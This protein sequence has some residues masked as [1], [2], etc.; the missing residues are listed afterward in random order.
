MVILVTDLTIKDVENI[1][2]NKKLSDN[3]KKSLLYAL[4]QQEE[5]FLVF[6]KAILPKAFSKPSP[7]FHK[8]VIKEFMKPTSSALAAPRNHAKSTLIGLGYLLWLI[9]YKKEEYIIYTS[10]N[11]VKSVQFIEPLLSEIKNNIFY[12]WLYGVM[13][14]K[15]EEEVEGINALERQD[16]F[17]VNGI[18]VQAFS[19][20]KNIRGLKYGIHRPSI[21]I[22]DDIE[23]DDRIINPELRLKDSD[24]LNRQMIPSL[25]AIKGRYKFIGTILHQDSLLM[26]KIRNLDGR[27]YKAI[28]DDGTPLWPEMWPL[29]RLEEQ[30]RQIGSMAFEQEYMNNP[31]NDTF[32][33]IKREWLRA[34]CDEN[35]SYEEA[36]NHKYDSRFQGVDFAFSDRVVADKSA[37]VGIGKDND[38]Y[39]VIS[40]FVRKGMSTTEQFDYIEYL[41]GLGGYTDNA[42][43]ENSIRSMSKE[44]KNYNFPFTLFWTGSS[45]SA[46]K[47]NQVDPEFD[48]KRHTV[49]KTSM[50]KRLATQ[51]ENNRIRL[52][53][54]TDRD[55]VLSN[56]IMDECSTYA[57]QDGKLVEVGVHGDIP[58]ALGYAL[59]RAEMEKF[60]FSFG[61]ASIG[62]D[63][64]Y[65]D[66]GENY[67]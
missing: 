61:S 44:L 7:E 19:F 33:L 41:N 67:E 56:M 58:V 17:D 46:F 49:G 11:H 57:L 66:V 31:V 14:I 38:G 47:Q 39:T 6:C 35:L 4:F 9:A 43:E 32:S 5:N 55:K 10:Q 34:C 23:S 40:V 13:N 62:S 16:V 65:N 42:L 64:D 60:D 12:K 27:I 3:D 30:K 45:D 2:E 26:Q 18:R 54:K 48:G 25:D 29:S 53:F 36:F 37:F 51:F 1:L 63:D 52:P 8:E 21:I 24:K 50:I 20:E 59:E 22:F 15:K 28:K